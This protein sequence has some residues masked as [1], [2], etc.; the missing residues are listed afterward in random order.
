M[1][2]RDVP[3][4]EVESAKRFIR[5]PLSDLF[6]AWTTLEDR[7][8]VQM[9]LGELAHLMAFYALCRDQKPKPRTGELDAGQSK[10]TNAEERSLP[11]ATGASASST[12][13]AL[14]SG[15]ESEAL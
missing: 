9:R 11:A 8:F 3:A 15:S 12:S 5:Q 14:T 2:A 10:Q 1:N 7:D 4:V 6:K 13:R